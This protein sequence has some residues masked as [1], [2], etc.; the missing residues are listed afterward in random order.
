MYWSRLLCKSVK[1]FRSLQTFFEK[2][3]N[4][5][6]VLHFCILS[7]DEVKAKLKYFWR[8]I[9]ARIRQKGL[10]P[11]KLLLYRETQRFL[12][13]TR[14]IWGLSLKSSR[15]NNSALSCAPTVSYRTWRNSPY[16]Q[17]CLSN[18]IKFISVRNMNSNIVNLLAQMCHY[19]TSFTATNH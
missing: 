19:S 10:S 11:L 2:V 16:L 15:S 1:I 13:E 14:L 18:R 5:S 12:S 7:W 6:Q 17:V 9:P 4:I 8:W 3:C